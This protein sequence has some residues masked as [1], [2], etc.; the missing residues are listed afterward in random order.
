MECVHNWTSI[1]NFFILVI[2]LLHNMS[3]VE[4]YLVAVF[5]I[6]FILMIRPKMLGTKI[7]SMIIQNKIKIGCFVRTLDRVPE[8]RAHY[9]R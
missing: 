9:P 3:G 1:F 6:F 8:L 2:L 5:V 7:K 4:C